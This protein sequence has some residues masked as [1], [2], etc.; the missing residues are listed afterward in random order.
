MIRVGFGYD[1]H[2]LA[3]GRS[4]WL[5]CV[6]I[7]HARGLLGHSDGDVIAHALCDAALGAA[8]LGDLG[9]HFPP[10]DP[11]WKDA[12]G[13]R[14]LEETARL[15]GEVGARLVQAD[16]T[17]LAETPRLSPHREAM[18][19]ALAAAWGCSMHDL[20]LKARTHEGLGAVGRGEAIAAY[21]VVLV[22]QERS[23]PR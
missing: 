20:S 9:M 17:V 22:E 7:P 12:P 10:G 5:G 19:A 21:A 6:H 4:L 11:A 15:L 18:I 8:A 1:I 16:L 3:E 2:R 23:A 13:R 14:L